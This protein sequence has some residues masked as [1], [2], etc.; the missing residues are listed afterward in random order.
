MRKLL[1]AL[2]V[3][4]PSVAH[5]DPLF[6]IGNI[7]NVATIGSPV[8]GGAFLPFTPGTYAIDG[9]A[10]DLKLAIIP[11]AGPAHAE[12]VVFTLTPTPAG[13]VSPTGGNQ[14]VIYHGIPAAV[15]L[16]LVG[17]AV[18]WFNGTTVL[19]QTGTTGVFGFPL[20]AN[21]VPGGPAGQVE[22]N[23]ALHDPFGGPGT[24]AALTSGLSPFSQ[25]AAHGITPSDV[26]S[27]SFAMEFAPQVP[28][29]TPEPATVALFGVGLL[30]FGVVT[31]RRKT[32]GLPG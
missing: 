20:M 9:G 13:P 19:S 5:A 23:L 26:T 28:L 6:T 18:Q 27:Y 25:L 15:A 30:G 21:P 4:L 31:R 22:A 17:V 32:A 29:A 24:L 10:A 16:D 3:A 8:N 7:F 1:L 2:S 11:T 14:L 12:W